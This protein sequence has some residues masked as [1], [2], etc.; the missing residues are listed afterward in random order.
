MKKCNNFLTGIYIVALIALGIG[1]FIGKILGFFAYII[2]I[3][4]IAAGI[5][6]SL[7]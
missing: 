3:A 1:I 4:A 5:F 6:L 2:A 7:Q